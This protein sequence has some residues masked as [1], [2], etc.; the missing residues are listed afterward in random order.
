MPVDQY[1]G[2]VEH[3]IL[4]LLYSRFF[5]RAIKLNDEKI[6]IKEPFK[7]LFTQGMV[8]HETYKTKDGNWISPDEIDKTNKSEIIVGPPE[9][10]SKSKKNVVDPESMIKIYGAD[11]I[12]WFMLSDSPPDRDIQWSNEGVVAAYKFVQRVWSL[13]EKILK[14]EE[15]KSVD[16]DEK[17]FLSKTNKYLQKITNLIEKFQLNVAIATI[18]EAIRFME[19][20]VRKNVK[21]QHFLLSQSNLMKAIMPFMPHISCEC[22]SRL[23]GKNFYSKVEWPKIQKTFLVENE[24]VIVV[25][26]NGKKRGLFSTKRNINEIDAIKEAKKIENIEKN[27][28]NKKIIKKIFVKNKIINFITS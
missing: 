1:I 10:M 4:H 19:E 17:N 15:M 22:L 2:G 28:K 5:M 8:C 3:A 6:K 23:E 16:A 11:A 18:Y 25:Q 14:R 12:R 26:V 27:L 13:N 20:N 9:A 24:V 7:G 21:N